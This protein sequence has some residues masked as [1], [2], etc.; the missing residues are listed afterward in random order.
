[1][2]KLKYFL[3]ACIAAGILHTTN[4]VAASS[5]TLVRFQLRQGVNLFGNI[6]VELFDHDKP[7]TV[8]NFL[9]YVR[10]G[11]FNS[12][13]LDY[14]RPGYFVKGGEYSLANPYSDAL[15]DEVATI[16]EGPSITN[17][18][19]TNRVIPNLAGTLAM[20]LSYQTEGTNETTIRDSATASWF[21]NLWDNSTDPNVDFDGQGFVVFGRVIK[22]MKYLNYFNTISTNNYV[23]DMNYDPFLF[24]PCNFPR[25]GIEDTNGVSFVGLPIAFDHDFGFQLRCPQYNDLMN[26]NVSILRATNIT[27]NVAPKLRLT[28]PAKTTVITNDSLTVLGTITDAGSGVD[29]VRIYLNTNNPILATVTSSNTFFADLTAIPAGTNYLKVEANDENGNR[30]I[31]T[32]SFFFEV[33][34]PFTLTSS[35]GTGTGTTTGPANGDQLIVDRV[36]RLTA[37]ADPTNRFVGWYSSNEFIS[38]Q[39]TLLFFMRTNTTITPRFDTNFFPF[40]KGQYNGLFVTSGEVD[41]GG[42][43]FVSL[44]IDDQGIYS[45]KI[46]ANGTTYPL[47]GQFNTSMS[48]TN[49]FFNLSTLSFRGAT[50]FRMAFDILTLDDSITGTVTNF[51]IVRS[52][53]N[54]EVLIT[55]HLS[56]ANLVA[57]RSPAFTGTNTSP[58]TGKYTMVFPS[59][60]NP[61]SPAGDGYGTVV[62][63]PKGIATLVGSLADGTKISQKVPLSKN[64]NWP[65]YIAPLKTNAAVISWINF[66]TNNPPAG[67][68]GLYNWF[69]YRHNA[70]YY[71]D[72]FTNEATIVGSRFF[73]P[74]TTN[75]MLFLTNA[76]VGFTNGNLVTDFTN[77]VGIA[78]NGKVVNQGSNKLSLSISS[79]NGLMSGT[80]TPPAGGKAISF[81]GVILQNQTN[82][83]GYFLGT[84]A[85]GRVQLSR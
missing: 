61:G 9:S 7:I 72:G 81:K 55:N 69:K 80:V 52:N 1:M 45:A 38:A 74:D 47:S 19:N 75:Q 64:G 60:G 4:V 39:K 6:D 51:Y 15:F 78:P 48:N 54:S 36:Y 16:P 12:T 66:D 33:R 70:K 85:S 58:Y 35:S 2:N 59:D 79:G 83:A 84:N 57:D 21:F 49:G 23:L 13:F 62:V 41:P 77:H 73:K 17:E 67:F 5:N 26:V 46:V 34:L 71:G 82:A 28:Y 25:D 14:V 18:F 56:L 20:S 40:V 29:T 3:L 37:T 30:V 50:L 68:S 42:S 53:A 31:A 10:S 11:A 44:N 65:L 27:D 22:G 76:I 24:S 8:A 63:S 43:G 32:T